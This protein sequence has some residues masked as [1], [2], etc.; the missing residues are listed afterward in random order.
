MGVARLYMIPD[1]SN[2]PT[3]DY[4]GFFFNFF[5]CSSERCLDR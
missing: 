5:A 1:W 4:N 2:T 3:L